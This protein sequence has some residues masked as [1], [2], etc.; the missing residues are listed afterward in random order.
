MAP[1]SCR[2]ST[3]NEQTVAKRTP[4]QTDAGW[5]PKCNQQSPHRFLRK[6]QSNKSALQHGSSYK[7]THAHCVH[8]EERRSLGCEGFLSSFHRVNAEVIIC[9][10]SLSHYIHI[11][12]CI[13]I[14]S[15]ITLYLCVICAKLPVSVAFASRISFPI[16]PQWSQEA[17]E[18]APPGAGSPR[19]HRRVVFASMSP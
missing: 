2:R 19:T 8:N 18:A 7:H 13:H 11:H 15:H 14:F 1:A 16:G 9:N 10:S 17:P 5:I 4:C 3:G 6:Q 12:T